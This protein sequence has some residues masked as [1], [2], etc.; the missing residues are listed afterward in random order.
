MFFFSRKSRRRENEPA[1][2]SAD[3]ATHHASGLGGED[4]LAIVDV[5]SATN[6]NHN[7]HST[8]GTH[9]KTVTPS[10]TSPSHPSP[11]ARA[12]MN[13]SL[14]DTSSPSPYRRM[15]RDSEGYPSWLPKRPPPPVPGSTFQSSAGMTDFDHEFGVIRDPGHQ[16]GHHDLP[17]TSQVQQLPVS[18]LTHPEVEAGALGEPPS[19]YFGGRKPTPR[20]VRIVSL[21]NS[22]TGKG[23][24]NGKADH[25]GR[26]PQKHIH[27]HGHVPPGG[28]SLAHY[29][30]LSRAGGAAASAA[31]QVAALSTPSHPRFNARGLH[32]QI[33]RSPNKWSRIYFY[34]YPLLVFANLPLQTFLDLNAV[35]IL[36]QVSKFPNPLA[37]G[38][39]GSG[40]NWALGAAAYAACWLVW[41]LIV[42]VIYEVI[43]SFFRRWRLKR[44][45]MMPL[46]LSSS[47]FNY[48]CMTSY[49]NFCF[50]QHLRLSA[51]TRKRGSFRDGLAETF[52][53]YSQNLPTV[54]LLLPRAALC[55]SLLFAYGSP[56]PQVV[57]DNT[58]VVMSRDPTF[59]DT[60]GALSAYAIGV[61]IVNAAWTAW[62]VMVL[63]CSWLGLWILS[64]EGCAGLCGPRYRWQEEEIEKR[65]YSYVYGDAG[66]EDLGSTLA[67]SW[68]QCTR[69]RIQ[70]AYQFCLTT[71]PPKAWAEKQ[72]DTE[73]LDDDGVRQIMAAIG[74]PALPPPVRRGVLSGD[75]FQDPKVES[76]THLDGALPKVLKRSSKERQ[77]LVEP[78]PFTTEA[79][80]ISSDKVPFPPSPTGSG[81][82]AKSPSSAATSGSTHHPQST[83]NPT[84][85]SEKGRE[86]GSLSSFGQPLSSRYPFQFRQSPRLGHPGTA[87]TRD[88]PN[89]SSTDQESSSSS[90]NAT[91]ESSASDASQSSD[92]ASATESSQATTSSDESSSGSSS[93]PMPPRHPQSAERRARVRGR[94]NAAPDATPATSSTVIPPVMFP[95]TQ[96]AVLTLVTAPGYEEQRHQVMD[97]DQSVISSHSEDDSVGLLS[98]AS[99]LAPRSPRPSLIASVISGIRGTASTS[100][101]QSHSSVVSSD[102][103]S[104]PLPPSSPRSFRSSLG[105]VNVSVVGGGGRSRSRSRV[106]RVRSS[107]SSASAYVRSRAQ[108]L[109]Q[110]I[111]AA[112]QSSI[113]LVQSVINRSRTD[114]MARLDEG[115]HEGSIVGDSLRI[116][117]TRVQSQHSGN[118]SNNEHTIHP[119]DPRH[120]GDD[121]LENDER[122]SGL[123]DVQIQHADL[124]YQSDDKTHSRNASGGSGG[125]AMSSSSNE[126]YT[127]GHPLPHRTRLQHLG[128]GQ[129]VPEEAEG[130]DQ[131]LGEEHPAGQ[132]SSAVAAGIQRLTPDSSSESSRSSSS[133]Q[134]T[135]LSQPAPAA[136][137]P[138]RPRTYHTATT[139]GAVTR[140]TGNVSSSPPNGSSG[141]SAVGSAP[142]E[143][144]ATR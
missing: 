32:L 95:R 98:P 116:P 104:S 19:R 13:T 131:G 40:R 107:T 117:R 7:T 25:H 118:H 22:I 99:A 139:A 20:S 70:H 76:V 56:L 49:T 2:P 112:S 137:S 133:R 9:K 90:A 115:E 58:T 17:D 127:F 102:T 121:S 24:A 124:A 128:E 110:G 108:S 43:F 61:L 55:L 81:E 48:V 54:A 143:G 114:S 86:S 67:W 18:D 122:I 36:V 79:A 21:Q 77:Q 30:V 80:Q 78:Y 93:I 91:A 51:F 100:R 63:L 71:Q 31:A 27:G 47:A 42:T 46:Y 105:S 6:S 26:H 12:I 64:E 125:T 3:D 87:A 38:I 28:P 136:L 35:F 62:R 103:T 68:R 53:F 84:A 11:S 69:M 23:D 83:E 37:P 82:R 106:R 29:P 33:F 73:E 138:M 15:S 10:P 96:G 135:R 45:A 85:S 132:R 140:D 5:T 92:N 113:D 142:V 75:L 89:S 120:E 60:D 34:L 109:M 41:I 57:L 101:T 66:S 144:S 16:Q 59:F 8:A 74:F 130:Q 94:H 39:S 52:Y 14:R 88:E 50:M 111:G 65:R 123:Y 129:T 97:D 44:P 119:D 126:N 134:R 141:S 4:H 1:V 72:N